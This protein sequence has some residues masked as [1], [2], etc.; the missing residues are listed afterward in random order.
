MMKF[1]RAFA[2]GKIG[3]SLPITA[4]VGAV[5]GAAL[6][7]TVLS[8][9]QVRAQDEEIVVGLIIKNTLNPYW[10][11][12]ANAAAAAA[13]KAG[14]KLISAA[15]KS[16]TDNGAQVTAIEQMMIAGVSTILIT[17]A[18]GK[19]IVPSLQKA[20][21]A[22]I[23]VISLDAAPDPA[24]AADGTFATD[25]VRMG[26]LIGQWA[27][28]KFA[29]K[30]VRIAMLDA[31]PASGP[32]QERHD[33]FLKGF[34]ITDD[35]PQ[36]VGMANSHAAIDGGVTAMEILLQKDPGINLVYTVNEPAGMGAYQALERA[37]RL[38]DIVL[39]T[40]DGGCQGIQYLKDGK[41]AADSQ[42]YPQLMAEKGIEAAV[43][44]A[45]T[46]QKVSGLIGTGEVL[47]TNDPMASIESITSEEGV[48][49]C[50]GE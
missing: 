27:K 2:R 30:P 7:M 34:G 44:F 8:P 35:D 9:I 48:Q 37:G 24:D 26:E 14:V 18:D 46:G 49:N 5:A 17:P 28:D 43:T 47:V 41:F 31:D 50:W 15:G 1:A 42:Q 22:G 40:L 20:R 21:D 4:F 6:L 13:E 19:A 16:D 36:I 12:I 23:Q 10:G 45:K 38:D 39:L 11:A 3:S 33:G 29:G 32:G 25:H